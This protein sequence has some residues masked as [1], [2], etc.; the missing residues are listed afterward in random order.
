MHMEQK[1]II[2][3]LSENATVCKI[4]DVQLEHNSDDECVS[5][6]GNSF[7][8]KHDKLSEDVVLG[9]NIRS[10]MIDFRVIATNDSVQYVNKPIVNSGTLSPYA[11]AGIV[12]GVLIVTGIVIYIVWYLYKTKKDLEEKAAKYTYYIRNPM[13]LSIGIAW[14]DE[15]EDVANPG[16]NGFCANLN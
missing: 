15:L 2:T 1:L 6:I 11:I 5:C 4:C 10:N 16:F 8:I 14:Y 3:I 12:I 7:V 13:V 9:I